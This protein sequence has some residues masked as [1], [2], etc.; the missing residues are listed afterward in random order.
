[1]SRSTTVPRPGRGLQ[2]RKTAKSLPG[3]EEEEEGGG[4]RSLGGRRRGLQERKTAEGLPSCFSHASR[5]VRGQPEAGERGRTP[6]AP[7]ASALART[8]GLSAG[9]GAAVGRGG[10]RLAALGG[11]TATHEERATS[12]PCED[13]WGKNV[14]TAR[15]VARSS[16][17][18]APRAAAVRVCL[19][20]RGEA[21]PH[22]RKRA[23]AEYL[24]PVEGPCQAPAWRSAAR[25][26]A[27][28]LAAS[29]LYN[30]A[31]SAPRARLSIE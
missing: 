25:R 2:E 21:S 23:T 28:P 29:G 11:C 27:Q 31:S 14:S 15:V 4:R 10:R 30:E 8:V 13:G 16:A 20:G 18:Q 1:P 9:A 22:E 17:E 12:A 3:E 6:C 26:P 5:G 19:P 24:K 7:E